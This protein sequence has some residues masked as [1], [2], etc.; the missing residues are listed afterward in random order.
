MSLRLPADRR[1]DLKG[2]L[3]LRT[4]CGVCCRAAWGWSDMWRSFSS[5]L[6]GWAGTRCVS[7]AHPTPRTPTYLSNGSYRLPNSKHPHILLSST[8]ILRH[9]PPCTGNSSPP[10]V[11]KSA[12][13]FAAPSSPPSAGKLTLPSVAHSRPP[14]V[15][16]AS[17]PSAADSSRKHA[18]VP[19]PRKRLAVPAPPERP[20][21]PAPPERS[22]VPAPRQRLPEPAPRQR[23]PESAPPEHPLVPAPPERQPERAP[24][25]PKDLF[26]GGEVVGL[27]PVE[28][29]VGAGAAAAEADPPW[30]PVSPDPPWPPELPDPPWPPELPDPPWRYSP[31]PSPAP[32]SRVP[33]P[34]S[35]WNCYGAGRTF[36]EGEVM[37]GSIC[38]QSRLSPDHNLLIT[39]TPDYSAWALYHCTPPAQ[40]LSGLRFALRDI[41]CMC[42]LPDSPT[43]VYL[44]VLTVIRSPFSTVPVLHRLLALWFPLDLL[45]KGKGLITLR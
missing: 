38:H 12:P 14:A 33:T 13:P 35:R 26:L 18:P 45:E 3:Q 9:E 28:A 39:I 21:V 29:G 27:Q 37:S 30:P 44:L 4:R 25:F 31:Y 10:F 22:P 24:T 40:E 41:R 1:P 16:V 32:A 19:A 2:W 11:G 7:P 43:V 42:Y 17:P 6:T 15:P 34:T 20:P 23:P 36:R 8:S 5:S